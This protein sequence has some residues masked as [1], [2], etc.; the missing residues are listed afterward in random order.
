MLGVKATLYTLLRNKEMG[1]GLAI[2][3]S[4]L[5]GFSGPSEIGFTFH[6]INLFGFS[7]L[8]GLFGLSG[9]YS[10][11]VLQCNGWTGR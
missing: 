1:A 6:G 11:M 4:C 10:P 7:G 2:E 3:Q 5:S 8:F 9:L